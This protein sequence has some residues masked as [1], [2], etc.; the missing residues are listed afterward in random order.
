MIRT[1]IPFTRLAAD[2]PSD[3]IPEWVP[4]NSSVWSGYYYFGLTYHTSIWIIFTQSHQIL[5][6]ISILQAFATSL[7]RPS[8]CMACTS[9]YIRKNSSVYLH[10][11]DCQSFSSLSTIK[12]ESVVAWSA[13]D[14]ITSLNFWNFDTVFMLI[15]FYLQKLKIHTL[16]NKLKSDAPSNRRWR[17][18]V[19]NKSMMISSE[20]WAGS[21]RISILS[22]RLR[23]CEKS[24][25]T[26]WAQVEFSIFRGIISPS[27]A[28]IQTTQEGGGIQFWCNEVQ[29]KISGKKYIAS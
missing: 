10:L 1:V 28:R 3:S 20:N 27:L 15:F 4:A 21:F 25:A 23:I 8:C 18:W 19:W 9:P 22:R 26:V 29:E 6:L 11:I 14:H 13:V 2:H 5:H 12:M 16:N 7:R 24:Q 17:R